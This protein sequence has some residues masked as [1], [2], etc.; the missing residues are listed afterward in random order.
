MHPGN[1]ES[2]DDAGSCRCRDPLRYNRSNNRKLLVVD[3]EV[4]YVGGFNIHREN[5]RRAFGE[6]R[7][8]DTHLRLDSAVTSSADQ[9][10]AGRD[11]VL[12]STGADTVTHPA[13]HV[14][15]R[16][17]HGQFLRLRA[18]LRRTVSNTN[19]QYHH[20]Y[21]IQ[22]CPR[23]SVCAIHRLV[24]VDAARGTWHVHYC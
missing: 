18:D 6:D 16:R 22:P 14:L 13:V 9:L 24:G 2:R 7:W 4:D 8:R 19:P 10:V 3:G 20:G 1:I 23:R 15:R 21:S 11:L 17:R 12:V 5:S